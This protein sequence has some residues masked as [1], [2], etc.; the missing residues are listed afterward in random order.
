MVAAANSSDRQTAVGFTFRWSPAI[1]AIRNEVG[2]SLGRAVHFVG[3]YWCDY[4]SDARAPMS[5][6]YK[7]G[8]GSG[9][10]AD[11]GSHLVDLAEF[12]CGPVSSVRG[13]VFS[14]A[15][16]ER[17]LPL[18]T[19]VGHAAAQTSDVTEPVE[20]EDIA[21]FTATFTSGATATLS[22]SRIAYGH[23][24]ALGFE[25]FGDSGAAKFDLE[26]AGE[27]LFVDGRQRARR[28]ATDRCSSARPTRTSPAACRWTFPA[29]DTDKTTCSASRRALSC[30]R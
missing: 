18:G 4:G 23:P 14:T 3:R 29:S 13:A 8:P 16:N 2:G 5:W 7:G 19:A 28:T 26:R 10:L 30:S 17:A 6:R 11:I 12:V 25:V 1:N 15:V 22:V 27:F 24:N 21:T 20:N 9:A